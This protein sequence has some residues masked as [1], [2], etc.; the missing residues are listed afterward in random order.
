[1][2]VAPRPTTRPSRS[3]APRQCV[4]YYAMDSGRSTDVSARWRISIVEGKYCARPAAGQP[5]QKGVA[6][7]SLD[8]DRGV[9]FAAVIAAVGFAGLAIFQTALAAGAPLGKAA[10]GGAHAHLTTGARVGSVISVFVFIAATL[11]V[12]GC[13]GIGPLRQHA[14]A[15]RWGT[16]FFAA[17]FALEAVA[18]FASHSDYENAIMGP[19]SVLLAVLCIVVA[20][21]TRT[22]PHGPKHEPATAAR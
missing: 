1:M 11:L 21:G 22:R 5:D 17:V 8:A 4:G 7:N 16:W 9:R 15:S 2:W 3:C 18:N 20:R 13:A 6:T 12:L 14:M 10:W 19:L